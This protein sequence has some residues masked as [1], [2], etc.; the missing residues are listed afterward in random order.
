MMELSLLDHALLASTIVSAFFAPYLVYTRS[1][2]DPSGNIFP[3]AFVPVGL[4]ITVFV[5]GMMG[6]A[7]PAAGSIALIFGV[8]GMFAGVMANY[9]K[10]PFRP[11]CSICRVRYNPENSGTNTE[12]YECADCL[13]AGAVPK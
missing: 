2:N 10:P 7:N 6:P 1:R 13:R 8:C 4:G 11:R 9:E 12:P 3:V 5:L